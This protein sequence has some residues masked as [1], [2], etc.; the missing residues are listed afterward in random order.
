MRGC[1][2]RGDS[3]KTVV[4]SRRSIM[5]P[6]TMAEVAVKNEGVVPFDVTLG[7]RSVVY[8]GK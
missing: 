4:R 7:K 3:L 2:F 6:V 8:L 5:M 1:T